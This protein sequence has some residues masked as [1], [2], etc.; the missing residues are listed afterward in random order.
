MVLVYQTARRNIIQPT[1]MVNQ[2]GS[3]NGGQLPMERPPVTGRSSERERTA[4]DGNHLDFSRRRLLKVGIAT[5]G[6]AAS[7]GAAGTV[8][9]RS[10]GWDDLS[11]TKQLQVVRHATRQYKRLQAMDDAGYVSAPLPL[12][13]GLGYVF[14]NLT[15]WNDT[16]DPRQPESLFYVLNDGGKL[17]L[18]GVEFILVTDRDDAGDP[19]DPMPDLFNDES[20]APEEAPLRGTT[21][22][23]GWV[24]VDDPASGVTLWV[25]HVW[26]HERNPDGV[27]NPRNPRFEAMPGCG[28]LG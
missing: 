12:V 6:L 20:V 24:L 17:Q 13:C 8:S 19:V 25:L 9:A 27:F 22:E 1:L 14:D 18:A 11:L 26:V 7:G 28:T 16:L 3:S 10:R 15:L 21:E 2:S 4:T 5:A 23:E